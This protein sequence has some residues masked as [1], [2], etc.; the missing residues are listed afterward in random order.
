MRTGEDR[1]RGLSRLF[2]ADAERL[3]VLALRLKGY[4]VL[5]RN[6]RGHGGEIDI[7]ARRGRLIGAVEVKARPKLDLA[8]AAVTPAQI[9]RIGAAMRQFRAERRLDDRF[10][11]RCD[12]VLVVPGRWPRH[13][14]DVGALE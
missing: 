14:V 6:Y 1:A 5:A 4:G 13:V 8:F 9:R 2:G 7:V 12:A 10:T 11:F 3:A